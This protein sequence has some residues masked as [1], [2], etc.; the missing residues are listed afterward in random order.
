MALIPDTYKVQVDL[1]DSDIFKLG[2]VV[3]IAIVAWGLL[4]KGK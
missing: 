2:L 1:D 4:K 3:Y